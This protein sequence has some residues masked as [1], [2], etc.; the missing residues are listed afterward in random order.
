MFNVD[1]DEKSRV[2]LSHVQL[3]KAL[4]SKFPSL[5][6][7]DRFQEACLGLMKAY[8]SYEPSKSV[9]FGSYARTVILN[10]LKQY[11]KKEK[12]R[13]LFIIQGDQYEKSQDKDSIQRS[14]GHNCY[15]YVELKEDLRRHFGDF[16]IKILIEVA[17]G[18]TQEACSQAYGISQSSVSR[19]IKQIRKALIEELE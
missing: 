7:E 16:K 15:D 9:S 3:A 4:S 11:Y 12:M 2:V 8:R 19:I 6:Y 10:Q 18:K 17:N 5:P 14:V 13:L 1:S